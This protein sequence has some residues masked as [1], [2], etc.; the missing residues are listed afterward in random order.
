TVL[1]GRLAEADILLA[2]LIAWTLLAFDRLRASPAHNFDEGQK[3]TRSFGPWQVWRWIFFGLL[4]ITS[5]VK[6]PGFGAALTLSVLG[7]VLFW[8]RDRTAWRRLRFPAG[9][10]LAAFLTLAWP[11]AMIADHGFRV[12]RLWLLHISQRV[13]TPTGHGLFAGESWMEYA[14]N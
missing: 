1:R 14:L 10:I 3:P 9:W 12:V 2:C 13:G 7:T 11:L 4:G 5:L 8:D 6:G